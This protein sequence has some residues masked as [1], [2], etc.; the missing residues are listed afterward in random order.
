MKVALSLS[1]GGFRATLFHLGVI[2]YLRRVGALK[3]VAAVCGV[4][5]GAIIGAHLVQNW[6]RYTGTD[7]EFDAVAVDVIRL[8]QRDVRGRI[9]RRLPWAL[10]VKPFRALRVSRCSMFERELSRFFAGEAKF[11]RSAGANHRRT[12]PELFVLATDLGTGQACSFDARGFSRDGIGTGESMASTALRTATA[13]ATSASFPGFFPPYVV[14]AESLGIKREEWGLQAEIYLTDG[15]VFDN[16][17]VRKLQSLRQKLNVG[18]EILSDAGA[19]LEPRPGRFSGL[20]TTALRAVDI[21]SNRVQAL[22]YE[23]VGPQAAALAM[24]RQIQ[25]EEERAESGTVSPI[26]VPIRI[27]DTVKDHYAPGASIQAALQRVRTDLDEF[28]D[29]EVRWLIRHGGSVARQAIERRHATLTGVTIEHGQQPPW[30]PMHAMYP[31]REWH[32]PDERAEDCAW[33]KLAGADQRR[34]NVVSI[35]DWVSWVNLAAL[36]VVV[37]GAY[38]TIT[39]VTTRAGFLSQA[40]PESYEVTFQ[41]NADS[42][43]QWALEEKRPNLLPYMKRKT[44]TLPADLPPAV[45]AQAVRWRS[46]AGRTG[47]GRAFVKVIPPRGFEWPPQGDEAARKRKTIE[48][49][50]N[51]AS[52]WKGI[53]YYTFPPADE[54][55]VARATLLDLGWL[56]TLMRRGDD[57]AIVLQFQGHA[58]AGA[59]P[60][61]TDLCLDFVQDGGT[62]GRYALKFQLE[63]GSGRQPPL[64]P[65]DGKLTFPRA[66]QLTDTAG[67]QSVGPCGASDDSFEVGL[68][69]LE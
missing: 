60:K 35:K 24:A 26:L 57:S 12:R 13:V 4:S 8:T 25:K 45:K 42:A 48:M 17:G 19:T 5:G 18:V 55:D 41:Y 50:S 27:S 14:T 47:K 46:N 3:H 49:R 38:F 63:P 54:V 59:N 23:R 37:L 43:E 68:M 44:N 28:T 56:R 6:E 22:E 11:L 32:E 52:L 7:E 40:F 9:L 20:V 66:V 2:S 1:G 21:L 58:I 10:F 39:N 61:R 15:G 29:T 67:T 51:P 36:V 30:D 34:L 69:R 31:R 53:L 16:L 33:R 64:V 65:G 62:F